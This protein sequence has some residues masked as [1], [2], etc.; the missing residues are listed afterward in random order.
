MVS[1]I[2][3]LATFVTST[4]ALA[5]DADAQG[6]TKPKRRPE[7]G[8]QFAIERTVVASAIG[9]EGSKLT[10]SVWLERKMGNKFVGQAFLS[11]AK[12]GKLALPD[13]QFQT[14]A[15]LDPAGADES[16]DVGSLDAM[17]LG[18]AASSSDLA[19][20]PIR[21]LLPHNT[22]FDGKSRKSTREVKVAG[23]TVEFTETDLGSPPLHA[24]ATEM[25]FT[26]IVRRYQPSGFEIHDYVLSY[27]KR[28]ED[29]LL[30]SRALRMLV[31]PAGKTADGKHPSGGVFEVSLLTAQQIDFRDDEPAL[32]DKE[33]KKVDDKFQEKLLDALFEAMPTEGL[34][35][36]FDSPAAIGARASGLLDQR[37]VARLLNIGHPRALA[38]TA[39]L[40]VEKSFTFDP[41]VY[42]KAWRI[43][44]DPVE[45]LLLA[46][47]AAAGGAKEPRFTEEAKLALQSQDPRVLAAVLALAKGLKDDALIAQA[48]QRARG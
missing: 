43:A 24:D 38:S 2:A 14:D 39:P 25:Y 17:F 26:R 37:A 3:L 11:D 44:D 12:T 27:K 19:L 4:F 29:F 48:Q 1:R 46:A 8:S 9:T 6:L 47:G 5:H 18:R 31:H 13:I 36:P 21:A 7:G 34:G 40:L 20:L 22:H 33:R 28:P 15:D 32:E 10:G 45:R 16:I 23:A 42:V 30:A 35:D 41:A